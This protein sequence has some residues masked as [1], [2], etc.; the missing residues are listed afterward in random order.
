MDKELREITAIMKKGEIMKAIARLT[1]CLTLDLN[2]EQKSRV[3]LALSKCYSMANDKEAAL[4]IVISVLEY[5][6]IKELRLAAINNAAV[7]WEKLGDIEESLEYY[8]LLEEL[9]TERMIF[10]FRDRNKLKTTESEKTIK[11]TKV[12][13]IVQDTDVLIDCTEKSLANSESFSSMKPIKNWN[14]PVVNFIVPKELRCR[15]K[16]QKKTLVFHEIALEPAKPKQKIQINTDKNYFKYPKKLPNNDIFIKKTKKTVIPNPAPSKRPSKS[17]KSLQIS[18]KQVNPLRNSPHLSVSSISKINI[19]CIRRK[20][21]RKI[22]GKCQ[23][24]DVGSLDMF[25]NDLKLRK[26]ETSQEKTMRDKNSKFILPSELFNYTKIF[27]RWKRIKEDYC[28]VTVLEGFFE[29]AVMVDMKYNVFPM[30]ELESR[31]EEFSLE[32]IYAEVTLNNGDVVLDT[33]ARI[34]PELIFCRHYLMESSFISVSLQETFEFGKLLIFDVS[35]HSHHNRITIDFETAQEITGIPSE[36]PQAISNFLIAHGIVIDEYSATLDLNIEKCE[37]QKMV[38]KIQRFFRGYIARKI[39][40]KITVKKS[41]LLVAFKKKEISGIEVMLF[42]YI[43]HEKIRI[44]ALDKDQRFVLYI[45]KNFIK[46]FNE[47]RKKVIEGTIFDSLYII[48]SNNLRRLC[49]HTGSYVA[50]KKKK[51]VKIEAN[52]IGKRNLWL[53]NNLYEIRLVQIESGIL[54]IAKSDLKEYRTVVKH[55]MPI[56]KILVPD[57]INDFYSRISLENKMLKFKS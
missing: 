50:K 34:H 4:K 54:I 36:F 19:P 17:E 55:T 2:I 41:N 26:N 33:A 30:K 15:S 39:V 24:F 29:V 20:P 43:Q 57:A 25:M 7:L 47:I 35:L 38:V 51:T 12:K 8:R 3:N 45:D 56:E 11:E 28:K 13:R 21:F 9:D 46:G 53:D 49:I 48:T 22:S 1:Q 18:S 37:I 32:I 5:C 14:V 27:E 44:E 10:K 16:K 40:G 23:S 42:A 31:Y 52:E 6:D